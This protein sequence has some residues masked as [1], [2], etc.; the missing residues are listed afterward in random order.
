M[1][2]CIDWGFLSCFFFLVKYISSYVC[3]SQPIHKEIEEIK[4]YD[5]K[6]K[7]NPV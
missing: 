3:S 6:E 1:S 7:I 5:G 4:A 2:K